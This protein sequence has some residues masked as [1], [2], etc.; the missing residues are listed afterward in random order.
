MSVTDL[1]ILLVLY[2]KFNY[3]CCHLDPITRTTSFAPKR[4]GGAR[5]CAAR[6]PVPLNLG[7][8]RVTTLCI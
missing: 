6:M 2:S 1:N 3:L 5:A 7:V 8:P 4:R